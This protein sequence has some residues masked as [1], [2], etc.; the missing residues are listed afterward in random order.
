MKTA[1]QVPNSCGFFVH[2]FVI[3][4]FARVDGRCYQQVHFADK[5]NRARQTC[6]MKLCFHRQINFF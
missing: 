1:A 3:S 5:R 4:V 2:S 6:A